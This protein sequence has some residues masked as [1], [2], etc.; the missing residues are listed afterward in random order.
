MR[1][2]G[3]ERVWL[4]EWL[5]HREETLARLR[6]AV[7]AAREIAN[8][9]APPVSSA[10]DGAQVEPSSASALPTIG[11][12]LDGRSANAVGPV[13]SAV[14]GHLQTRATM[15]NN[16]LVVEYAEW[17]PG[18]LGSVGVLDGL[19]GTR[20]TSNVRE[21]IR[22]AIS[23]EGPINPERLAKLV[24]GAYGLK[25]VTKDRQQA[26]QRVVPSEFKRHTNESFYWPT[27]IDPDTWRVVRRPVPGESRPLDDVS[28]VEIANA[29]RM[30][31][32]ASGGMHAE[33][34]K[35][36]ALAMFGGRRV[37]ES[38][39]GRLDEAMTFALKHG[40]VER[41]TGDVLDSGRR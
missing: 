40:H 13:R 5:Q 32:E 26:I 31:A 37:T 4:P 19:P 23:A 7:D 36:D 39:G 3:V 22:S 16:P 10:P 27:N 14:V 17:A 11:T 33:E 2:P 24:A 18:E 6:T 25:R 28:L 8:R 30:V 12:G 9:P 15:A 35:R 20:A 1:W 21:A 38:I 29:M 41:T 34:L